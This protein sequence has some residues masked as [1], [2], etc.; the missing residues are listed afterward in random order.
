MVQGQVDPEAAIAGRQSRAI[1]RLF[2]AVIPKPVLSGL[3][4]RDDEVAGLSEVRSRVLVRRRI[5]A[6]DVTALG[7]APQVEPPLSGG[8]AFDTSRPARNS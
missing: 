3:E 4:A 1:E 7:A 2:R 8:K 5:A 6:A